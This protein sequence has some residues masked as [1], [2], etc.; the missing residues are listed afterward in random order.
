M[1]KSQSNPYPLRLPVDIMAKFKVVAS[2]HSRSVNGE[3]LE[4]V[5]S[6]I[7]AYEQEHGEIVVVEGAE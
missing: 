4:L 1:S 7:A 3:V 6:S 2:E 5:K